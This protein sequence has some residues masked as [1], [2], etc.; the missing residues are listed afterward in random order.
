M[1]TNDIA[2]VDFDSH[3]RVSPEAIEAYRRDGHVLLRGVASPE[4]VDLVRPIVQRVV[5]EETSDARPIEERDA[6]GK[7]FL[8]VW[9]LHT[10]SDELKA[11]VYGRRFAKLAAELMGVPRVRFFYTQAFFKEPGGGITAWHQDQIYWPLDTEH[12]ITMWMPL[13]DVS[14]EM[15]SLQFVKGSHSRGDRQNIAISDTS[16]AEYERLIAD[17][18]WEVAG[19]DPVAAGDATFHSG[20]TIHRA[21]GNATPRMREVMTIVWFADGARLLEADENKRMDMAWFPDQKP[22]E[23]AG[24]P[25]TPVL[26]S[27]D[28]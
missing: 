16:E 18:G 7:A 4:E 22:G 13:V 21:P 3:H 24:G 25:L 11:F 14:P 6:F 1:T 9:G 20:W 15:G 10:K 8:Q 28:E 2:A 17:N 26:Y 27:A 5:R 19:N 12:T 23:P